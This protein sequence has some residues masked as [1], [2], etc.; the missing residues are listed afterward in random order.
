[1]YRLAYRNFGD[2]ESLVTNFTVDGA[3][4][5]S[6]RRPV[7][8]AARPERRAFDFSGRTYAPD[9]SHRFIGS[10]AMDQD[11]NMALGYSKSDETIHPSLAVTGRL[12]GDPLGTMGAEN[13]FFEGPNSLRTP[14]GFWG[15]YSSMAVDPSDDCTFWFTAEY[16]GTRRRS[17]STAASAP[18][19]SQL[20]QR[21][22]G[23]P[24]GNGD[25]GGVGHPVAGARVTAGASETMTDASGPLPVPGAS[26]GTYAMTA[27]QF[28]L[29]PGAAAGVVVTDGGTTTQDFVAGG[30][31]AVSPER[32]RPGRLGRGWPLYAKIRITAPDFQGG[33]LH[34]PGHGLLRDHAGQ[35]RQL[36]DRGPGRPAGL[37]TRRARRFR[38]R[39]RPRTGRASSRTSPSRS[40]PRP[41]TPRATASSPTDCPRPST[42]ESSRP[43]GRSSTT[44][45]ARWTIHTGPDPA[46]S[47]TGNETGGSGPFALVDSACD[48]EASRGHGAD[49]AV[50]RPFGGRQR[51]GPL[52]AGFQRGA[53]RGEI[54]DVDVSTDGGVVW[55][56]VL[57]QTVPS[58][59]PTRSRRHDGDRRRTARR[60]RAL[61]LLQRVHRAGGRWTTSCSGRRAAR[62]VGRPRRRQ[63]LRRQHGS[64]IDGAT[65]RQR[66]PG[67]PAATT[68][69]TPEDPAQPDGLYILFSE[70]ADQSFQASLDPY[71]PQT[72]R[73]RSFPNGAQRLDFA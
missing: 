61:P 11:G 35:R 71:A 28:G 3:G 73:R 18:S 21:P 53:R 29:V 58:P 25:G 43:A 56:N 39:R 12:V 13:T 1:M 31:P 38:S 8:G 69:A 64:G 33:A 63:R 65:V 20:H 16:I 26:R 67:G 46:G 40:T 57:H 34:R 50:R 19:G 59:A 10:I 37:R 6:R 36:H 14:F 17:S 72:K 70:S 4:G 54:A 55:T 41:A 42:A 52:R 68:F 32:R 15:H 49:H 27:T 60:A 62:P 45:H 2:H 48:G 51:P 23:H 66:R 22:L 44:A 5:E 47:S 30:R 7:A 24:R 9:E